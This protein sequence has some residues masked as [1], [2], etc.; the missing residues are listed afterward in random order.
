M[1][2]HF[3]F[4]HV[5]LEIFQTFICLYLFCFVFA[6]VCFKKIYMYRASL[7]R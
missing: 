6:L 7:K 3:S 5:D 1:Y 2:S 4:A